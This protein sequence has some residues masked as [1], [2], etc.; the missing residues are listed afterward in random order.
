MRKR[1]V[2]STALAAVLALVVGACAKSS[3]PA[4]GGSGTTGGSSAS[5]S[6]TQA[7]LNTLTAGTLL[8][9]SCLDYKPFEFYEGGDLKGFDVEIMDAIGSNLGLQV[10]W[11]KSNFDTIFVALSSNEFDAVAAASTITT[12]RQQVVSFSNPYY[13]ARQGFTVNTAKSP[14]LTSTDQLTSSDVI[15]VQKGTTGKDWAQANLATK[16]VQIKT[17]TNAPDAFTDLE[18]GQITGIINDEPSSDEEVQSR[19]GLKV[20]EAIDTNEHYGIAVAKNR[21]DILAAINTALTAIIA[22]GTYQTIFQ[23]YFPG[24][25]VPDEFKPTS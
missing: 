8:V 20:V 13:N 15:G 10:Q 25:E 23:K 5:G 7:A 21:P 24:V 16:G 3:P 14:S 12:E 18:A 2:A 4:S 11:K 6:P 9:G 1:L 17:Y 22:D 19:P